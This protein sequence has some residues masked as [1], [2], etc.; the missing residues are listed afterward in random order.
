MT[1]DASEEKRL[2]ER[3]DARA[4]ELRAQLRTVQEDRDSAPGRVPATETA[5]S[6]EQGERRLRDAVREVEQ[7]RDAEE[8]RAIGEARDR[9][10]GGSYGV[11]IDCGNEI[12]L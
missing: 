11:C 4:A 6:G 3:L 1:I 9:M 10:A 8:L 12:R 7:E 5:D 2:R